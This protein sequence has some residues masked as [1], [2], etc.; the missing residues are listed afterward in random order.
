[1]IGS[2]E[3]PALIERILAG[4]QPAE[5][6]GCAPFAARAPPQPRVL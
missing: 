3:E 5:E 1:M 2:I 4:L 6:E